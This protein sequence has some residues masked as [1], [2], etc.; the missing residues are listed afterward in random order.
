MKIPEQ[1]EALRGIAR[2]LLIV[3]ETEPF[4][5]RAAKALR[6]ELGEALITEARKQKRARYLQRRQDRRAARAA[7]ME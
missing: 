4:D 2:R 3:A 1:R 6:D 5:W 7:W